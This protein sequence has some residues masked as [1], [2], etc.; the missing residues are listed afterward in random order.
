MAITYVQIGNTITLGAGGAASIDITS[1]PNTYT[2]LKLVISTRTVSGGQWLF[3]NVNGSSASVT[4][5]YLYGDGGGTSA[6]AVSAGTLINP[7]V[8]ST[9]TANTFSNNEFYFTNYAGSLD[10]KA[11][12]IS[13][14]GENNG[15]PGDGMLT[16]LVWASTSAINQITILA[17]S[18]NLAQYSTATLYGI[19]KA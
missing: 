13:G 4:G 14:V 3:I 2:D 15:A 10:N 5:R 8:P 19:K 6:G 9:R 11:I 1:I 17:Q 16:A 18:Q 7:S 12:S